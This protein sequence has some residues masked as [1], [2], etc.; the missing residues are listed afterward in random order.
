MDN[1]QYFS[2]FTRLFYDI[3]TKECYNLENKK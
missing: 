2:D 1:H 3:M